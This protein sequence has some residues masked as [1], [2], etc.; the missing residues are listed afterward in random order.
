M[1]RPE[2]DALAERA[3][4]E[5]HVSGIST[6]SPKP[7][8]GEKRR[9]GAAKD[10]KERLKR[11]VSEVAPVRNEIAHFREV[12]PERLQKTNVACNDILTIVAALTSSS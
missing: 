9:L 11:A 4:R 6:S 3:L 1:L 10:L 12:P 7:F 2:D 5:Q 8:L